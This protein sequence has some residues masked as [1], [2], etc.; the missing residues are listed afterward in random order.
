ME[1]KPETNV[2][3]DTRRKRGIQMINSGEKSF[4]NVDTLKFVDSVS[5]TS[6]DLHFDHYE[7]FPERD[8]NRYRLRAKLSIMKDDVQT[9]LPIAKVIERVIVKMSFLTLIFIISHNSENVY[10]TLLFFYQLQLSEIMNLAVLTGRQVAKPLK[11]FMVSHSGEIADV[12]LHSSCTSRDLSALKVYLLL[13][14]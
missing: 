4:E 1:S 2:R 8:R 13:N 5:S 12:T 11:V 3:K 9:V 6:D 10:S 7:S 14:V